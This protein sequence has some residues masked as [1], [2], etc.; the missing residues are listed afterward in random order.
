V[1]GTENG[2]PHGGEI[3][4][5]QDDSGLAFRRTPAR[6]FSFGVHVDEGEKKKGEEQ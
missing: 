5:Y 1:F 4:H 3:T 2:L 6:S